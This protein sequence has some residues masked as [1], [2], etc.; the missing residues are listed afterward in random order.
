MPRTL[1]DDPRVVEMLVAAD[2]GDRPRLRAAIRA[3]ADPNAVSNAVDPYRTGITAVQWAAEFGSTRAVRALPEEGADPLQALYRA[4]DAIGTAAFLHQRATLERELRKRG[5][6]VETGRPEDR[7][8]H[9][10]MSG[11]APEPAG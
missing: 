5:F 4:K 1:F 11:G 8:R 2:S 7:P 9:R 10:S 3:G 6:P